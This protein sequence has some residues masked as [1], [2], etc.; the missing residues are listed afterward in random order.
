MLGKAARFA[1]MA[2]GIYR[3]WRAPIITDPEA[4][5][6]NQLRDREARFLWT[7]R[8]AIFEWPRSPYYEMFRLAGCGF[9]DLERLVRQEGLEE[10]LERL[11]QQGVYLTHDELKGRT[12]IVRSGGTI[13]SGDT[14]F[15]N[16]LARGLMAGVT[17]GSRGQRTR[18]AV[19][20]EFQTYCEAYEMLARREFQQAGRP[21]IHLRALLPCHVGLVLCLTASRLG[22]GV[23]LW[24]TAGGTR[25]DSLH[26]RVATNL[27][28]WLERALGARAPYPIDLPPN[29]FSP[30][31]EHLARY[32][33]QGPPGVVYCSVS[34][35]VRVASAALEKGADIRGT[36]FRIG[37]ETITDAKRAVIES[38]GGEIMTHYWISEMG[39]VGF[40][41]RQMRTGD[42]VHLFRDSVA[43]ISHRRRAPLCEAEVDSLM[44]T[45]LLP[46]APR[47]LINAETDDSGVLEEAPCDC[48]YSRTGLN[49]QIRDIYSFGK[50]TGHA[51]TLRRFDMLRILETILP[52]RFGGRPGDYQLVEHENGSQTGLTLRVSP[53]VGARDSAAIKDR[54]L[55]EIRKCEGG[56]TASRDLRQ[57]EAVEVVIAEPF[58]TQT[59]KVLPL[60]LLGPGTGGRR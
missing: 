32:R 52:A 41:C 51:M 40:G 20:T 22:E 15:L 30:V 25:R 23:E 19:S 47:V 6:R 7:V 42:S 13:P 11:R 57:A 16:P 33:A 35:A 48:V 60:H 58:V 26:Y 34:A 3:G 29:D 27:L 53:R 55:S 10:A 31:V 21:R 56:A 45:T 4:V 8:R 37:G 46:F 17:S 1:R 43:A 24:F 2:L 38:A 44:F 9:E 14:S 59:G 18:T 28:V 12:A 5:I 54:F 39:P 50:L 49:T 36:L